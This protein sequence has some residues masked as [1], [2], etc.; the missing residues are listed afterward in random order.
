MT[1]FGF[2]FS[3]QPLTLRRLL[4]LAG[5][6]LLAGALGVQANQ[7]LAQDFP[8]KKNITMI[9]GFV[10]GG[11]ADTGARIIAKRLGENLSVS[12]TVENKAG[13]G[14]NIAHQ[15]TATGPADGSVLLL[16]S[17]GPLA[18]A[19]HMMKLPY[20][21]VKDLAPL[22]MAANFPN[23]LVVDPGAGIK[24]FAEFV[25]T[26]RKNPGKLTFASTGPGSASHLAG[27][28]LNDMAK[29]DT[30]HVPY[31]G[32]AAAL[33]DVLGGRVTGWY[34]TMATAAPHIE[35]GKLIP[36]ASTGTQRL[37]SLPKVP[38]IAES[39]FPGF[40][41]TNWYAFVASSKVPKP[42]LDR[43]NTEL[44]KVLTAP[45]VAEQLNKHGL[46]PQ[47]GTRDELARYMATDTAMWGR[48][49]RERKI[50]VD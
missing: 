18:I 16:G 20:D 50:V 48:V 39:G 31:K 13:A 12:V 35:A 4:V 1:H 38:T 43:W 23:V 42:V 49:I 40:N 27:E 14:G 44:V 8:P 33:Q 36:L 15:L 28:L 29:L 25:A 22:T 10:A 47:P 11:A 17:V 37:P 32:G 7:A 26:A 2:S 46:T 19:P 21:P 45:D 41:A 6:G 5:T 34:A 30:V 3:L 9:V 24:T